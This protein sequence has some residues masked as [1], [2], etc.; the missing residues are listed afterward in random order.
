MLLAGLVFFLAF[1][2]LISARSTIKRANMQTVFVVFVALKNS[3]G[4]THIFTSL[5][6]KYI[7]F[8]KKVLSN[9]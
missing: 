4:D 1:L 9:L 8:E 2:Y 5:T 6:L 7:P 3:P